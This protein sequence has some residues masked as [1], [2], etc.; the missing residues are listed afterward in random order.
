MNLLPTLKLHVVSGMGDR[1]LD[2]VGYV[3]LCRLLGHAEPPTVEWDAGNTDF[4]RA[5][6]RS[7]Y[8]TTE[9]AS[10]PWKSVSS[11]SSSKT[12]KTP[13]CKTPIPGF[14]LFPES[15]YAMIHLEN[16]AR[17]RG[18][19]IDRGDAGFVKVLETFVEVAKEIRPSDA[20][21][22]AIPADIGEAVGVHL[23]K[24]D[25][26]VQRF[27][28]SSGH[29]MSVNEFNRVMSDLVD[30]VLVEYAPG[31][32]FF[33]CSEDAT[34]RSE[35]EA[36][37]T[38]RSFVCLRPGV[39]ESPDVVDFFAMS[40]CRALIQ[41]TKYS[42]FSTLAA[43]IGRIPLKNLTD[44]ENTWNHANAWAPLLVNY[45]PEYRWDGNRHRDRVLKTYVCRLSDFGITKKTRANKK[46]L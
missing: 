16:D 39:A 29:E 34:H 11:H 2:S 6:N 5:R 21:R 37:L 28:D 20:V 40:M 9:F 26:I 35:F 7:T 33:V 38:S 10:L 31:T 27:D 17:E 43:V 19:K 32:K 24:S 46:I 22:A 45:G 18:F 44:L 36:F 1:L 13:T 3:T 12:C 42:T 30:H 8:D 15:I 23:R 41:G 14:S 4:N 25:K